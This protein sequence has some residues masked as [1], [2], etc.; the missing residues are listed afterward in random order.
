MVESV[1]HQQAARQ[2]WD[3]LLAAMAGRPDAGELFVM[4][5]RIV[6]FLGGRSPLYLGC[7][8]CRD[9]PEPSWQAAA[10]SMFEQVDMHC[11]AHAAAFHA[12]CRHRLICCAP[13]YHPANEYAWRAEGR[14]LLASSQPEFPQPRPES[15]EPDTR[16]PDANE[17]FLRRHTSRHRAAGLAFLARE[18]ADWQELFVSPPDTE[19]ARS[20]P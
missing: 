12:V 20:E 19:S 4:N 10:Y 6:N 15:E 5:L 3:C 14:A 18:P 1:T 11:A 8:V 16:E 9:E 17:A 7:F 13:P 2:D